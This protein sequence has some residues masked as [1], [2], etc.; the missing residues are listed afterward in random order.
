ML[1]GG[2]HETTDGADIRKNNMTENECMKNDEAT[3]VLVGQMNVGRDEYECDS[4]QSNDEECVFKRGYCITHKDKGEKRIM[5]SKKWGAV[6][7]VYGWI[8]SSR[9]RYFCNAKS[10]KPSDHNS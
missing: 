2:E 1:V 6:K 5:K 4:A 8:H 9:V 10:E 7:N 3:R